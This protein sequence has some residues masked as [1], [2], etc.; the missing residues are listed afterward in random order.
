M[1]FAVFIAAAEVD[2]G[3]QFA[4][5]KICY[6]ISYLRSLFWNN[7]CTHISFWYDN[8]THVPYAIKSQLN[9]WNTL[10]HVQKSCYCGCRRQAKC[11]ITGQ[12]IYTWVVC[13]VCISF[14]AFISSI[15]HI[16]CCWLFRRFFVAHT[17]FHVLFFS[18]LCRWLNFFRVEFGPLFSHLFWIMLAFILHESCWEKRKKERKKE[19]EKKTERERVNVCPF[20]SPN[21]GAKWCQNR[22]IFCLCALFYSHVQYY[23][24][25]MLLSAASSPDSACFAVVAFFV[26]VCYVRH[27]V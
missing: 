27:I 5:Y 2:A 16:F 3:F 22:N 17:I 26:C 18:F 1:F 6:M 25:T 20:C 11:T 13:S 10:I 24:S 12:I 21:N 23:F 8:D 7:K 9:G 4:R 15:L 19:R 14:F